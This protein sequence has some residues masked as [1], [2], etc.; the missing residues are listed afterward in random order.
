M[1]LVD[2]VYE[3][4]IW[5]P[6][7][8][9]NRV[10][11]VL[12]MFLVKCRG[13]RLSSAQDVDSFIEQQENSEE[14]HQNPFLNHTIILNCRS[15]HQY[16]EL[17]QKFP[18]LVQRYGHH[19]RHCLYFVHNEVPDSVTNIP[20]IFQMKNLHSLT[21]YC[22]DW[23]KRSIRTILEPWKNNPFLAPPLK[24]FKDLS[25]LGDRGFTVLKTLFSGYGRQIRRLN[26]WGHNLMEDAS[27]EFAKDLTE[28]ITNLNE[29]KICDVSNTLIISI[30]NRAQ[31]QLKRL[32]VKIYY[33]DD[34]INLGHMF[35]SIKKHAGTLESFHLQVDERQLHN[36]VFLYNICFPNV[37]DL[38][39]PFYLV[40]SVPLYIIDLGK[41]F[42][43][44][45]HLQLVDSDEPTDCWLTHDQTY[46]NG[47]G[48]IVEGLWSR[49]PTGLQVITVRYRKQGR[50]R[51][52]NGGSI[53]YKYRKTRE[54]FYGEEEEIQGA[55]AV[56]TAAV[57]KKK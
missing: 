44:M 53:V 55:A 27:R 48:E 23:D 50:Q 11:D 41:K 36:N 9:K 56:A 49:L 57:P 8:A 17:C 24:H 51:S 25:I 46:E 18:L 37:T 12:S 3:R 47:I 43:G 21:I 29:F 35:D 28:A 34:T 13:T 39:I 5:K 4:R 15:I 40:R 30:C 7:F 31:W 16:N 10:A 2:D 19:V 52:P 33:S 38:R 26:C 42:P 22:A 14:P 1:H 54:S 6:Y 45:Q 20:I 32:S